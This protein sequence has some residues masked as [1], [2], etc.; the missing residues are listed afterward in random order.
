MNEY[1]SIQLE[2]IDLFFETC[3]KARNEI[4]KI[5]NQDGPKN[6]LTTQCE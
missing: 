1:T 5:N 6:D 4:N 2:E 3:F